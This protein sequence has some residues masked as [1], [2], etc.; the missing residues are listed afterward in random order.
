M[1]YVYIYLLSALYEHIATY[2]GG[3]GV[4]AFQ[5][6]LLFV[7]IVMNFRF[8]FFIEQYKIQSQAN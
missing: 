2:N 6:Y 7:L 4:N 3:Q 1:T 8:Q 5:I